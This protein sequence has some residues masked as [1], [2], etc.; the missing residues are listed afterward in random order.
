MRPRSRPRRRGQ[1]GLVGP[2]GSWTDPVTQTTRHVAVHVLVAREAGAVRVAARVRRRDGSRRRA[3]RLRLRGSP[4]TTWDRCA[5]APRA[6][7]S[8]SRAGGG[9]APSCRRR[10]DECG[11]RRRSS[12]VWQ[13]V[14]SPGSA[15]RLVGVTGREPGAMEA[16]QAHLAQARASRAA[17]GRCP[18]RGTTRTAA[19]YGSSRTGRARSPRGHHA[20]GRS[21]RREQVIVGRYSLVAQDST[22]QPSQSRIVHWS[23]C[24]WHPKQVAIFGRTAAD[25]PRPPRSGSARSRRGPQSCGS[26]AR[27]EGARA[28][29][30]P[31]GARR[32]RRGTAMHGRS[33]WGFS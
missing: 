12:R 4:R 24:W 27:S 10:S 17:R 19:R 18:R 33:S 20:R 22:W 11:S 29:A 26:G 15:R 7:R 1:R 2:P 21:R 3:A 31:P 5:P 32:V 23:R 8:P 28:R 6:R 25:A 9:Y 14:Q 13:V 30:P 16:G